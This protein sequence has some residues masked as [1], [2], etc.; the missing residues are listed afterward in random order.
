MLKIAHADV[1]LYNVL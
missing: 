1:R